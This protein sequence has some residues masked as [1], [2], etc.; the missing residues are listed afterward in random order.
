MNQTLIL[1]T[2]P[3]CGLCDQAKK[4]IYPVIQELGWRLQ[5][6]NIGDSDELREKYA[7]HIPVIM[8]PDGREKGW[9]FTAGQIKRL[10]K[11]DN[12]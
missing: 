10:L 2:G 11:G 8:T 5:E 7:V 9:P 6:V 1:Y 12:P 4:L 3:H